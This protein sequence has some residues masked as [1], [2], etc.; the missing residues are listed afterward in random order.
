M[1][2]FSIARHI[3]DSIDL[4]VSNIAGFDFRVKDSISKISSA[5]DDKYKGSNH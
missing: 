2:G 5:N 4:G 3:S 1:S